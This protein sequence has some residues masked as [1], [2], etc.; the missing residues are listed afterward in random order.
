MSG[1]HHDDG[2]AALASLPQSYPKSTRF[3]LAMG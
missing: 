3:W 1:K 2:A